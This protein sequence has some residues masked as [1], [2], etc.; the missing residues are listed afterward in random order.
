M[1]VVQ[2]IGALLDAGFREFGLQDVEKL[3]CMIV[4]DRDVL[5]EPPA[6]TSCSAPM[7]L[8]RWIS[9]SQ[10]SNWP[11]SFQSAMKVQWQLLT[12]WDI[13]RY[14]QDGFLEVSQPSTDVKGKPPVLNC[15]SILMLRGRPF[16]PRSSQ[17]MKPGLTIISR[18]RKG[19]QWSGIIR[20]CQEKEVQDNSFCWEGHDHHLLGH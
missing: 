16:C 7:T 8:F 5:P 12:L 17:V 13:R 3:S 4:R 2:S 20:N 15:W 14:A 1:E 9:A 11:Y 19:G 10:A 18:R 6:P